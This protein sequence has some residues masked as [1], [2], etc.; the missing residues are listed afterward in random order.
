MSGNGEW[1]R[2][3][4]PS[5]QL[6]RLSRAECDGACHIC[7][8]P[9]REPGRLDEIDCDRADAEA[10]R[11]LHSRGLMRGAVVAR[12]VKC[13]ICGEYARGAVAALELSEEVEREE[14]ER[15]GGHFHYSTD[16]TLQPMIHILSSMLSFWR[17]SRIYFH[18]RC[19]EGLAGIRVEGLEGA[20]VSGRD[21]DKEEG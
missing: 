1:V 13:R 2:K 11:R 16:P 17:Q 19:L 18:P 20:A 7:G 9:L 8:A 14:H 12:P 21:P 4:C 3:Y 10:L 5:C 6:Y 15:Y